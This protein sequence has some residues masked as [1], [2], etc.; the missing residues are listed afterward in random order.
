MMYLNEKLEEAYRVIKAFEKQNKLLED[1]IQK[2]GDK[3]IQLEKRIEEL[4]HVREERGGG[5]M[6][7]I[8]GESVT[9]TVK[10]KVRS[11]GGAFDKFRVRLPP[12]AELSKGNT[13]RYDLTVVRDGGRGERGGEGKRGEGGGGGRRK[14][15]KEKGKEKG[16]EGKIGRES[17]HRHLYDNI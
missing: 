14:K 6:V 13:P 17:T 12:G 1:I 9:T 2:Q 3:I 7:E 5:M 4:S 11:L 8:E 16:T 10:L 15:K